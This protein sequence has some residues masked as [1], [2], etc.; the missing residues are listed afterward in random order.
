MRFFDFSTFDSHGKGNIQS[1]LIIQKYDDPYTCI[2]HLTH[3]YF[4]VIFLYTTNFWSFRLPNLHSSVKKDL[5]SSYWF[6]FAYLFVFYSTF[7]R[8]S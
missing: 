6:L 2:V 4:G 1:T 7:V 3:N 8:H 5:S